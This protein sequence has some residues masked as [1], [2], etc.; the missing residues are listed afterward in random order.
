VRRGRALAGLV[1]L[2]LVAA[3]GGAGPGRA[4]QAFTGEPVVDAVDP[5]LTGVTI[6]AA[7]TLAEQLVVENTTPTLLEALDPSGEVFLRIGPDGVEG[8]LSSSWWYRSTTPDPGVEIPAAAREGAAPRWGRVSHEPSWGW[9]DERLHRPQFEVTLRYGRQVVRVRGHHEVPPRGT[10]RYAVTS[11]PPDG[12]R[13]AVLGGLVPA[14]SV[15]ATGS[16]V[17]T[18]TG[19][20]GEPFV[21]L[22]P[23]GAEVNEASPSWSLTASARRQ[24]P[25]GPVGAGEAPRWRVVDRAPRLTWLDERLTGTVGRRVEWNVPI[26]VGGRRLSVSGTSTWVP[27]PVSRPVASEE[28]PLPW[29]RRLAAPLGVAVA[30]GAFLAWTVLRTRSRRNEEPVD[31]MNP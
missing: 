2:V 22:G 16:D 26:E 4:H 11:T 8:N 23:S 31:T 10:Y 25:D 13:A 29:W 19:A 27:N 20:A 1:A 18:V 15:Q 3:I 9:F 6:Q 5:P 28:K 17:V 21:R 24:V 12:L 7:A 14:L 30:G